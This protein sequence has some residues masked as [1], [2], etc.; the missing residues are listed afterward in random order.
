MWVELLLPEEVAAALPPAEE[1]DRGP[2]EISIALD[3]IGTVSNIVTVAQV[4]AAAP[5]LARRIR[6]WLQSRT[7]RTGDTRGDEPPRLMIKG[8]GVHVEMD[9]PSNIPAQR[10][11]AALL[12]ALQP[13][14][15][16]EPQSPADDGPELVDNS[17][18]GESTRSTPP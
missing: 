7:G 13:E 5:E 15:T 8:P 12:E 10:I 6:H 14:R 11:V 9:L 16:R 1:V 18:S 2:S 3:V 4:T 17:A